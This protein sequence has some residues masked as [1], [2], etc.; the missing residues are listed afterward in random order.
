[1]N[2]KIIEKVQ[3]LLELAGN[4]P[5]ENEA[6]A[7]MLKAQQLMAK[8]HIEAAQ[9]TKK[10]EVKE[11]DTTIIE[12]GQSTAWAIRLANII[13]S[14]FRCNLLRVPGQGLMFVGLKEDVAIARGVYVFA[15]NVLEKNMKKLRRQYRKQGLSTEGISQDYAAGFLAGLKKKYDDQVNQNEWA[16]VLVKDELVVARTQ[17]LV[18]PKAKTY[19]AKAKAR[20]G[21]AGLYA[22]G[23]YDGNTLG[24]GQKAIKEA[25]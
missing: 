13:T 18:N 22:K 5:N 15:S 23:Y 20:R 24:D 6:Q 4:N 9:V 21:D 25:V 19:Q 1:M 2:E 16:L 17:E 11:V 14:N 3:K 10:D 7:A 12:G 8:Y